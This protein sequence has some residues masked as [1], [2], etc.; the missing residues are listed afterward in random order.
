MSSIKIILIA[1][2]LIAFS[3]TS[4]KQNTPKELYK[5]TS[6]QNYMGTVFV[7]T[8]IDELE[9][10]AQHAVELAYKEVER[11]EQLISSWDENS[12]TAAINRNAGVKPVKVSEELFNLIERSKKVSEL[13]GGVFDISFASIDKIWRFD[14]SVT[15]IPS[16]TDIKSSVEKINYKN[17]I[18]D[19]ANQTVFLKEK[20]MKIGFGAIGKGYAANRCKALMIKEGIKSGVVN[21]GGDLITWGKQKNGNEW[22]IGIADPTKKED[23][24]SWLKISDLSVV[25]SGN[26]ERFIEIDGTRYCHIINPKTGWP[27]K[28]LNSVTII[29]SDAE[30]GDAMATSVF[31]LGKEK[32]L[33]LINQMQGIECFIIDENDE[34]FASKNIDINYYKE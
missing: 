19:N 10:K 32:G 2:F 27:S 25:T 34:L 26:Y 5:F 17:I 8:A 15:S 16:E 1:C 31:I 21:A 9:E 3:V 23:A 12:E 33:Q 30:I 13:T 18:L 14:G 7:I 28:A 11:I 20:G 29:S 22:S 24:M 4:C 6:E